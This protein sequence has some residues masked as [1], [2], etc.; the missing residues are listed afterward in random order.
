[1]R[2]LVCFLLLKMYQLMNNIVS[3]KSRTVASRNHV[4]YTVNT[5]LCIS[6]K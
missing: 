4:S 2:L 5:S 1:M 6:Q 3:S